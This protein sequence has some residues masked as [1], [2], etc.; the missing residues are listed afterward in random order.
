M[1]RTARCCCGALT[2]KVSGEPVL[3][4]LCHC[5]DCKRRTGTAF[6]WSTYFREEDV[7]GT[8]GEA[9][10]YAPAS[11]TGTRSFCARCGSTLYWRAAFFPEMLGVA[12]GAFVD[13]PLPEPSA[14]YRDSNACAWLALPEG[15][16]RSG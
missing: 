4:A 7:L 15:W 11:G 8:A 3:N 2:V 10:T 9:R 5:D 14:S 1:E 6:G 13:S 16:T 12:G